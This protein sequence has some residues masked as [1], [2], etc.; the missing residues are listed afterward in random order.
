MKD[1][2]KGLHKAF[3]RFDDSYLRGSRH[4]TEPLAKGL[5]ED[6]CLG[7]LVKLLCSLLGSKEAP[8]RVTDLFLVSLRAD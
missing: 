5:R 2:S 7:G 3:R 4:F 8:S 6:P 1:Q